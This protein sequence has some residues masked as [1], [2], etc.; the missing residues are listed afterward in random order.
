M[1]LGLTGNFGSGKTTVAEMFK[2]L[3]EGRVNI[4][5]VD[6]I[7]HNVLNGECYKEV[8]GE[9]GSDILDYDLKI[10]RAILR[11]IVFSDKTK[12]KKLEA[13]LHPRM[14]S[15]IELELRRLDTKHSVVIIEAAILIELGLLGLIDKLIVVTCN[16]QIERLNNKDNELNISEYE[17]M[18]ILDNQMDESA[19][20]AKAH[21]IVDN[22]GSSENTKKQVEEIWVQINRG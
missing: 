8:L 9:F 11:E 20:E 2:E 4:I 3:G 7:G 22:N 5:D 1:I 12:L 17:I 15:E 10:D 18:Q 16:K 6:E 21:F 19:L 13:I 14:L